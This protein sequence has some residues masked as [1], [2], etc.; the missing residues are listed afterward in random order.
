[1]DRIT[2]RIFLGDINGVSNLHLLRKNKITHILTMAAGI[3]PLYRKEFKYKVVNIMDLPTQNI[4][5]YF[6]KAIEFI[7]KAVAGGGR[8][9]VHCFAGVSRSASTVIAYFMATRKMGFT[10]AFNYVKKKRPVI[11]PNYGFQRQL[12]EYEKSLQKRYSAKNMASC[13]EKVKGNKLEVKFLDSSSKSPGITH[14][15]LS[16]YD[17]K[18]D[19]NLSPDVI[20]RQLKPKQFHYPMY[21]EYDSSVTPVRPNKS[22]YNRNGSRKRPTSYSI[23]N[24]KSVEQ[25]KPHKPKGK[26]LSSFQ[27]KASYQKLDR[28]RF[29]S[30]PKSG[31]QNLM[32]KKEVKREESKHRVF[33]AAKAPYNQYSSHKTREVTN[34]PSKL[35]ADN[36]IKG[37]KILKSSGE[38]QNKRKQKEFNIKTKKPTKEIH[39]IASTKV[40]APKI[41]SYS[42]QFCGQGLFTSKDIQAHESYSKT[43][44]QNFYPDRSKTVSKIGYYK[45]PKCNMLFIN[46]KDWITEYDGNTGRILCPR[47]NCSVKLGS[48]SWAGIK[49]HCGVYKSPAFQISKKAIRE[50]PSYS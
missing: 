49:C 14:H 16:M 10:E 41:Y 7:N 48:Y 39:R 31:F 3:R 28:K 25:K 8:V 36:M 2:D 32:K 33:R 42:C 12:V 37:N 47:K 20:S 6:D 50:I 23:A 4:L 22:F 11:F 45:T 30:K 29:S 35:N 9:L 13:D 26:F 15:K 40:V 27:D 5:M 24:M 18:R 19:V 17:T 46:Q 43:Y 34:K 21:L 38:S 44:T 1:M